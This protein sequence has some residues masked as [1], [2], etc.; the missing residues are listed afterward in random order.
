[1]VRTKTLTSAVGREATVFGLFFPKMLT[2][3]ECGGAAG[4]SAV[5]SQLSARAEGHGRG[6]VRGT[7]ISGQLSGER[8][9][10]G[11]RGE[12]GCRNGGVWAEGLATYRMAIL[13]NGVGWRNGGGQ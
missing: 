13:S 1:M 10:C 2:G 6:K 8:R 4:L 7:A 3:G 12:L 9:S 11:R 5:S